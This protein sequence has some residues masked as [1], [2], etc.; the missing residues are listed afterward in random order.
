[1]VKNG[2]PYRELPRHI[3]CLFMERYDHETESLAGC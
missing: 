3:S 1:M 2:M